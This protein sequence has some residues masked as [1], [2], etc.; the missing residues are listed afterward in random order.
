MP[1]TLGTAC[2]HD[3]PENCAAVAGFVVVGFVVGF[4]AVG[5]VALRSGVLLLFCWLASGLG[6]LVGGWLAPA[7]GL[8]LVLTWVDLVGSGDVYI[9]AFARRKARLCANNSL[10]TS[11]KGGVELAETGGGEKEERARVL[12]SPYRCP[13]MRT[14]TRIHTQYVMSMMRHGMHTQHTHTHSTHRNT[15]DYDYDRDHDY[16]YDY[17]HDDH[18]ENDQSIHRTNNRG[19]PIPFRMI[20]F[21]L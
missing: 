13:Q 10:L 5:V 7:S 2:N 6:F 16:D 14:Q 3:A 11:K 15:R 21:H 4:V 18:D 9:G 17:D 1:S 8:D 12:G 20:F 19:R